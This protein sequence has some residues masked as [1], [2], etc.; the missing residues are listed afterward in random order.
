MNKSKCVFCV[1]VCLLMFVGC[2]KETQKTFESVEIVEE[3]TETTAN[4]EETVE[5]SEDKVD[6]P[7]LEYGQDDGNLD[8]VDEIEKSFGVTETL[9]E[10]AI[11]TTEVESLAEEEEQEETIV[12]S[13]E[14]TMETDSNHSDIMADSEDIKPTE[15]FSEID[16]VELSDYEIYNAMT[17]QQQKAFM[18]SFATIEDFVTWYNGAKADYEKKHPVI[19]IV[20][21]IVNASDL[22]K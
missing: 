15:D 7:G 2:R 17:G 18:E 14:V 9:E 10:S 1:I 3:E 21:G 12:S 22:V 13:S 16:E 11:E 6:I 8:V 5:S 19:E 20:D 4:T